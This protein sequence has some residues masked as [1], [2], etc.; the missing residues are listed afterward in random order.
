MAVLE[1]EGLLDTLQ[2]CPRELSEGSKKVNDP[3]P[4]IYNVKCVM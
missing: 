1:M 2:F 4:R 3:N